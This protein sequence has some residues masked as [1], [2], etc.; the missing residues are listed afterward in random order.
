MN[1]KRKKFVAWKFGN[2]LIWLLKYYQ[3]KFLWENMNGGRK[4]LN[5]TLG[6]N[7]FKLFHVQPSF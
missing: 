1:V 7:A 4:T 3:I 5:I 6:V 2:S